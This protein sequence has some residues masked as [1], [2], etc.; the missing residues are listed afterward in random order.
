M[1]PRLANV[2]YGLEASNKQGEARVRRKGET[3]SAGPDR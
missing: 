1:H 2:S 3:P